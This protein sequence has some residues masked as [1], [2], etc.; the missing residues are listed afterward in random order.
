MPITIN[1][2]EYFC[3]LPDVAK[4]HLILTIPLLLGIQVASQGLLL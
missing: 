2:P 1:L 4:P 3:L